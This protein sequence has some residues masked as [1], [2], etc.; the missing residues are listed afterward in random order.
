MI[1]EAAVFDRSAI[2]ERPLEGFEHEARLSRA[3][4]APA[5]DRAALGS[6]RWRVGY[7]D[8]RPS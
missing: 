8:E 3:R 1:N 6:P 2:V 7:M 5:A 4:D